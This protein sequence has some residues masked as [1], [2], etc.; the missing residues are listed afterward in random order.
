MTSTHSPLRAG[1]IGGGFMAAVHSRAVWAS[2]AVVSAVASSSS[3]RSAEAQRL[4]GARDVAQSVDALLERADVDVIHI[5]TPNATHEEFALRA[6]SAGKRIVCEK[7]LATTAT[8]AATIVAAADG[9]GIP[10]TV[11]FVYRFHPMVREMRAL[12]ASGALGVASVVQGSYLQDWLSSASS[13]NWRVDA[14]T[15]GRSRAFAD[16]GSHWFDVLEF[17]TGERVVRV[18]AQ[19]CTV[20]PDREGV[21]T[22]TEDA[23]SVQF[24]LA[25]GVIGSMVVSQVAAGRKNRLHLEISGSKSSM[26]FDQ[27]EPGSLWIGETT[28]TRRIFPDAARLSADAAR[29]AFLPAG[30]SQGYQDAFNAYVSETYAFFSGDVSSTV[31]LPF[32]VDGLRAAILCDAVIDSAASGGQWLDVGPT[33]PT[34]HP[35][36]QQIKG[37]IQ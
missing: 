36:T 34:F 25:N 14:L 21:A 37:E 2:G 27:E 7:P 15:G 3:E 28:G 11:P 6:L 19:V 4:T 33:P 22:T 20:F 26:A 31:G 16:I 17:V 10:G 30:H 5:C 9:A 32:L 18:S 24:A 29:F 23:A 35:L 8:A 1:I 13:T 12:I